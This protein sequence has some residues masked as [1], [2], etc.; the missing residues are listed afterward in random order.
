M[1]EVIFA[2]NPYTATFPQLQ[3]DQSLKPSIPLIDY[4]G[5]R[6]ALSQ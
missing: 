3:K 2:L 6:K 1:L 5:Y 4:R